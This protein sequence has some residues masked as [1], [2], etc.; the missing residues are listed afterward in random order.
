MDN[1]YDVIFD[2]KLLPGQDPDAARARL[3]KILKTDAAALERLFARAPVVIRRAVDGKMARTIEKALTAAGAAC[4]LV[5]AGQPEDAA[6]P[7]PEPSSVVEALAERAAAGVSPA[8]GKSR[9]HESKED[10][11]D[12]YEKT[13]LL[14]EVPEDAGDEDD[15]EK[16]MLLDEVPEDAG[17]EDDYEKTML[18]D[19]VPEDVGDE[20]DYEKTMLLDEVPE[21]AYDRDEYE[22]TVLLEDMSPDGGAGEA[23]EETVVMS[24]DFSAGAP[25]EPLLTNLETV[26]G[27]RL[28]R[29]LGLVSGATV[30]AKHRGRSF[31]AG[32]KSAAGGELRA[33]TALMQ[34]AREEATQ[35]MIEEA[36]ALGANAVVNIRFCTASLA[37]GATEL[38]VY[39]TAV[40]LRS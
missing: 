21:D 17:D 10:Q 11:D 7:H 23:Y 25:A 3:A 38:H 34:E 15:Y 2:G 36:R 26:P 18:L 30:R 29:H 16:T 40:I 1:C 20:D 28:V 39:G 37:G 9:I 5:P 35:R 22:K 14:D 12:D 6:P 4:R 27:R 19:E 13:M 33:Y 31:L 8:D 24:P 32:M